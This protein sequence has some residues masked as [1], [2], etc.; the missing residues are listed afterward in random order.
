MAYIVLGHAIGFAVLGYEEAMDELRILAVYVLTPIG[1]LAGLGFLW[2]LWLAPFKLLDEKIDDI[3]VSATAES[4][5]VQKVPNVTPAKPADWRH[6]VEL[7][8]YQVAEL[9]GGISPHLTSEGSN[10]RARATYSELKA[11]LRSGKLKGHGENV[12]MYTRIRRD[13]LQKYFE[14]RNDCPE[15]LKD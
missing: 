2:N 1:A 8:L 13:N 6:A 9:S 4:K 14:G 3:Q 10:D 5:K 11:S 15:F 12:N 7:A